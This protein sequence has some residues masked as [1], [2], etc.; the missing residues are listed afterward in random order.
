MKY[1]LPRSLRIA[2]LISCNITCTKLVAQN[3]NTLSIQHKDSLAAEK[4]VQFLYNNFTITNKENRNVDFTVSIQ[5]PDCWRLLAPGKDVKKKL[6]PNESQVIPVIVMKQQ[7]SPAKW[8]PVAVRIREQSGVEQV[9]TYHIKADPVSAFAVTPLTQLVQLKGDERL[10]SITTK[11]RNYGTVDGIYTTEF[12][13][14][15]LD[16]NHQLKLKLRPGMDTVFTYQIRITEN[17]WNR[18]QSE[19]IAVTVEDTSGTSY[20]NVVNLERIQ[21]ELKAHPSPYNTFPFTVETGFIKWGDQFNYYMGVRGEVAM[22]N[23]RSLNFFYRT[24]QYGMGNTL[25]RNVFGVEYNTPEWTLYGGLMND[26][27]Y[28]YTYGTGGRVT[29]RP[30]P[31]TVIAAGASIH[32]NIPGF[33]N[34]NATIS[35]QYNIKKVQM[36][37]AISANH[38]TGT[39]Y[40]SILFSNEALLLKKENVSLTINAGVGKDFTFD[41]QPYDPQDKVGFS[42]GYTFTAGGKKLG[43]V[44]QM[45]YNSD[46]YPG[47]TKGLRIQSHNLTWKLGKSGIGAFYQFNQSGVTTLRDTIYNTD[48][49]KYNFTKYGLTYGYYIKDGNTALSVGK[50]RQEGSINNTLPEYNF[51]ELVYQQKFGKAGSIFLNTINGYDPSYGTDKQPVFLTTTSLVGTYKIVGLKG[52]YVQTPMFDRSVDKKF[53]NY[54]RTILA[55]PFVNFTTLKRIRVNVFY[56]VSKS[57]YDNSLNNMLGTNITYHNFHNGLDINLMANIPLGTTNSDAPNGLNQQYVSL[58][59][60]KKFNIP[61]FYQRRYYTL[62]LLPFYDVNGNGIKDPGERPIRNLEVSI[63]DIAFI[64]DANGLIS[65]KHIEPDN[66][67]LQ[68]RAVNAEKG[69]IPAGG[70]SQTITVMK[71]MTLPLPF[72]KSS[73][74]AGFLNVRTDSITATN[75]RLENIKV[76]A[77][78]SAGISFSTLTDTKGAYFINVPAG[79]YIVSLN[80]EAFSDKI[81]PKV[82]AYPVDLTLKTDATVNFEIVDK[83]REIRFFKP[84][85]Q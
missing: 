63:N 45:Q 20:M 59:V 84:K 13:D 39:R 62:N 73:V 74:I 30:K 52:Y 71:D 19:K 34:D 28:F 58:N 54:Q 35:A 60:R 79:K 70:L 80:P 55:G 23:D 24:K 7:N 72:K 50:L 78:D 69:I 81:R 43:F 29:Y 33:T 32:N 8:M 22:P 17:Q 42:G 21:S 26:I 46:A 25:E 40:N 66:Y 61:I 3:G 12:K 47:L 82:M 31:G 41:R 16:L 10:V 36:T 65:Y 4:D 83:S 44:S 48:D 9:V 27:K 37:Q 68:F 77:T 64:S 5:V 14:N 57:L 6:G 67:K 51:A 49:L 11:I 38:D 75:V 76:I 18:L 1:W 15:A 85:Q 53:V 2:L 56:N